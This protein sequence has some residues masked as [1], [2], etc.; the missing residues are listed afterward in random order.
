MAITC[1]TKG[2]VSI[3]YSLTHSRLLGS[4][5][6]TDT[7]H[8]HSPKMTMEKPS[9]WKLN[10]STFSNGN[11]GQSREHGTAPC[12]PRTRVAPQPPSS[13]QQM[14]HT[15][16][17]LNTPS[18]LCPPL[19][20]APN[21]HTHAQVLSGILTPCPHRHRI[22]RLSVLNHKAVYTHTQ[23]DNQQSP[24]QPAQEGASALAR[25]GLLR[26]Q[27]SQERV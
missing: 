11:L 10:R 4:H 8:G 2:P 14:R 5:T 12:G 1:S 3:Y 15:A 19:Y 9:R 22:W 17:I 16:E 13:Q 7:L 23:S 24:T 25:S 21:A 18:C 26:C 20:A 27:L 6:L